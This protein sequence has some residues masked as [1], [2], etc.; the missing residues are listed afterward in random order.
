M[1]RRAGLG[2]VDVTHVSPLAFGADG[3][4]AGG[5]RYPLALAGA[6]SELVPTRLVVFG[7]RRKRYRV[8]TLEVCQLPIRIRFK[9]GS[10]NPVSE[11]L[12]VHVARSRALHLHQYHSVVTNACL[13]LAKLGGRPTFCTDHGGASYNY[14][15]RLSLHRLLTGFLPVSSFS[16]GMFPQLAARASMP[17]Y[18]G[19]DPGRFYPDGS[20]REREVVFVGRLIPHKGIDVLLDAIDDQTPVRIFGR[21]YDAAYRARL[22]RLAAGKQVTFHER[23]GDQEIIA[24]YRRARVAVLPSVHRSIDGRLHPWPELL[25]LSVLEAL[26][27]GTPVVASRLGGIPEILDDGETGRLVTPGDSEQLAGAIGELLEPSA[28]WRRMSTRAAEVV[29]ER[30]TW[31]HVAQRCLSAYRDVRG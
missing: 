25:G 2:M 18:G 5:E 1:S 3:M 30:F 7:P 11:L 12:P 16:A 6:M 26:A 29:R 4:W 14:A 20:G 13:L 19:V 27:C 8:G 17:L 22:G 9:G 31:R 23:A 15:D 21:P 28:T 24:A 10:V